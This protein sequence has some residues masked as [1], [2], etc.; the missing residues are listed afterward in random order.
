[1][2]EPELDPAVVVT[3]VGSGASGGVELDVAAE[4]AE[5]EVPMIRMTATD[6]QHSPR[7]RRRFAKA[8]SSQCRVGLWTAASTHRT[9]GSYSL[10]VRRVQDVLA[11][12]ASCRGLAV[13]LAARITGDAQP[14]EILVS[15]TVKDLMVGSEIETE[16]RSS[17]ELEEIDDPLQLY[18]VTAPPCTRAR[19]SVGSSG[20]TKRHIPQRG[21]SRGKATPSMTAARPP[22][23]VY[24][25]GGR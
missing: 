22:T 13:H 9:A 25:P 10:E 21:T 17:H 15:R 16:D 23:E 20:S 3:E 2:L 5:H 24:D 7:Q 6:W 8:G 18:A 12:P 19:A 1:M 14:D 4:S 11:L